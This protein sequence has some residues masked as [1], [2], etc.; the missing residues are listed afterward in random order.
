MRPDKHGYYLSIAAAVAER[1]TCLRRKYGAVIVKDD[2]IISTGYNG[3][4]RGW[5]N[6]CELGYCFR[7]REQIPHGEKYELCLAGETT[8]KLLDGTYATMKE[9]AE[10]SEP[11]WVYS[12]NERTGTIIPAIA[13][14]ARKTRQV[15]SLLRVKFDD[16]GYVD[17]TPEHRFL[18]RDLTY[19]EAQN[20]CIG[21]SVMPCN[22]RFEKAGH[23]VI[24]NT[25]NMRKEAR[26][27]L[28]NV[29]CSTN[30]IPTHEL[31]YTFFH[32]TIPSGYVIHHVD[33]NPRNN[34]PENLMLISKSE[35]HSLHNKYR[36]ENG[37][38]KFGT[39]E[40]CK[41]GVESQR[42]MLQNDSEF[43]RKKS[44]I[45]KQNMDANWASSTWREF[46][47]PTLV[48]N[49]RMIA[50]RYN[51]DPTAILHRRRGLIAMGISNFLFQMKL[52]NETEQLSIENYE[53]MRKKH[54]PHNGKGRDIIPKLK[55]VMDCFDSFEEAIE[56]GRNY[57][58]KV[59][60][61][62]TI[63]YN[64]WVYDITVDGFPNLAIKTSEGKCVV[65]HNCRSVH[66]EAN[67]II[68][69]PRRDM[70]GATLYLAGKEA[71]GSIIYDAEPCAMCRRLIINAG[72]ERVISRGPQGALLILNVKDLKE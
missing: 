24:H 25:P 72:I 9:L 18:L 65:V 31:V 55:T 64:D 42:A 52:S 26:W 8:V 49:G 12:I 40:A 38:T 1:S 57:N 63:P 36:F 32:G 2:E 56:A 44:E 34:T 41:K 71:D 60:S 68:S 70:I 51:S 35:H 69:A 10:R 21:D 19:K 61:I 53:K 62:E 17:C 13:H 39:Y 11:V 66:G 48:A 6:C 58:H 4:P 67:A 5:A 29:R 20:L 45:G 50:A 54:K 47:Q 16:G 37:L 28:N 30:Q 23:E 3:A 14:D 22:Y 59:L 43:M 15:T 7:E 27:V 33:F 46:M